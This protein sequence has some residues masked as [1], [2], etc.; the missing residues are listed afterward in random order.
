MLTE[1]LQGT[2]RKE[3]PQSKV[4]ETAFVIIAILKEKKNKNQIK[5]TR[6][7]IN[8][9]CKFNFQKINLVYQKKKN[10]SKNSVLLSCVIL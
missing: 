2:K 3:T 1:S 10:V 6:K 8:A 5:L 9:R 4:L 7:C